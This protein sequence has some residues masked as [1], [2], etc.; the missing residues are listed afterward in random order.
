MKKKYIYPPTLD[1][2]LPY[3]HPAAYKYLWREDWWKLLPRGEWKEPGG[4]RVV[5]DWGHYPI[6]RVKEPQSENRSVI[7]LN[8]MEWIVFE[9]EDPYF[10]N[11]NSCR[12]QNFL[13]ILLNLASELGMEREFVRRLNATSG[14][15]KRSQK[16]PKWPTY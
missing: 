12:N 16:W 10:D 5:Y 9:K 13:G 11:M 8:P 4:S 6:C 15:K 1:L 14:G 7:F 3:Y 2:K